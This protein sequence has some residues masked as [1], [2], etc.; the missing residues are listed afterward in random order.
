MET[1]KRYPIVL[2]V[3]FALCSPLSQAQVLDAG[4]EHSLYLCDDSIPRSWGKAT[5]GPLGLGVT[6][7]KAI[8]TSITTLDS[9]V[10]VAAGNHY[11]LFL[12]SNGKVWATGLNN[13]GQLGLGTTT[14]I[15]DPAEIPSLDNVIAIS[16]GVEFSLFL[17]SDGTVWA[18]GY[19]NQG[20]L[21]NGTTS[22]ELSPVQIS[23]A[24]SLFLMEDG[25]V[26][27]CGLN[28]E[29]QLGMGSISFGS[30]VPVDVSSLTGITAI[31]AGF[32]FS[33]FLKD[34]GTVWSC[35]S[36]D[37]GQLGVGSTTDQATPVQASVISDIVKIST[38]AV[39]GHAL[40]LKNDGTVWMCGSNTCGQ[41]GLGTTTGSSTPLQNPGLENVAYIAAGEC[42]SL[43]IKDD[44]TGMAAGGNASGGQLGIGNFSN[45]TSLAAMA[46]L[47]PA[48]TT[49]G[50]SE[51]TDDR[52]SVYPNPSNGSF[53]VK[54][55]VEAQFELI[56][57]WGQTVL[58][59]SLSPGEMFID[60]SEKAAGTYLYRLISSETY[61]TGKLVIE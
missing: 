37:A 51:N 4:R 58:S 3:V 12:K 26:K 32:A 10:A 34:D 55:D 61:Q 33:L 17:K 1:T 23:G 39:S 48:I 44:G 54:I 59:R 42:Y 5:S 57:M 50:I 19:N 18:C 2:L 21:G 52:F 8:P 6:T 29:G 46:D 60:I 16:A 7:N 28:I 15:D 30:N 49:V 22:D 40:F 25:T 31:D 9:I 43:F 41:F 13:K 36:N 24:H 45:T 38:G 14:S 56:S 11:S 27:A 20:Q 35:G 53:S 47:C